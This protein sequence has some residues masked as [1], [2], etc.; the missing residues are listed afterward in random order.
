MIAILI[1][2]LLVPIVIFYYRRKAKYQEAHPRNCAR[3]SKLIPTGIELADG[4]MCEECGKFTYMGKDR[5]IDKLRRHKEVKK[6]TCAEANQFL[7][8]IPAREQMEATFSAT[9]TSPLGGVAIDENQHLIK[10]KNNFV[11]KI[12]DVEEIILDYDYD[13]SG[14][15]VVCTGGHLEINYR[16][17]YMTDDIEQHVDKKLID[18]ATK[19]A[20]KEVYKDEIAFLERVT[21]LKHK[22]SKS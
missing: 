8:S 21:G 1:I 12:S 10:V 6:M 7:D 17:S 9:A 2:I 16:D 13:M 4:V 19:N 3:C 14:D 18:M 5:S 11:H 20:T 15:D 22:I